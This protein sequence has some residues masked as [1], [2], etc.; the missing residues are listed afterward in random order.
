MQFAQVSTNKAI[1]QRYGRLTYP[2]AL[3]QA[4]LAYDPIEVE[5]SLRDVALHGPSSRSP[6]A[7]QTQE[8][9]ILRSRIAQVTVVNAPIFWG[10]FEGCVPGVSFTDRR[11]DVVVFEDTSRWK[12]AQRMLSFFTSRNQHAPDQHS[13]HARYPDLLPA[14]LT[15]LPGIHHFQARGITL[16]SEHK[17]QPV[18]LDGEVS[19]LT[20]VQA[21]VAPEQLEL[22][23]PG[24]T[25]D[26]AARH[27]AQAM[28]G[29]RLRLIMRGL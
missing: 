18:S 23:V 5:L 1:R 20:P 12:L 21:C 16:F 29:P 22:L 6:L 11:L 13:W 17:P 2:F 9:L 28:W 3:W 15:N 24:G 14:E 10:V 19:M 4:F 27:K 8:H 26:N 7:T 25:G